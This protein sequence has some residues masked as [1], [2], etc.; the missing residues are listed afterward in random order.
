MIMASNL[1]YEKIKSFE[2]AMLQY[3]SSIFKTYG[4]ELVL[5]LE[6]YNLL[7]NKHNCIESSTAIGFLL[8]EFI[9]SKLE[10]YTHCDSSSEYVIDRFVG[11]TTAESYDFFSESEDIRFMVNVKV[12]RN[13]GTNDAIA[14]IGQLYKNY[15][16]E[17]PERVKSYIVLKVSYSIGEG[18]RGFGTKKGETTKH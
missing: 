9:V 4:K 17:Q 14:A 8:E 18:L 16:Q 2:N 1:Y 12:E 11:A 3:A 6:E 13:S 15:C 5:R 10:M 7:Q